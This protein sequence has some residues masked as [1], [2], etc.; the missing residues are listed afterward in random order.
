[1]S[2]LAALRPV[3]SYAPTMGTVLVAA[4]LALGSILVT[5]GPACAC[6]CVGFTPKQAYDH[7]D[8]VFVGRVV[9]RSPKDHFPWETTGVEV[10]TVEVER[11]YKGDVRRRQEIVTMESGASCGLEL[12]GSGPFVVYATRDSYG[13]ELEPGQYAAGL[14]DGSAPLTAGLER[15]LERQAPAGATE[16]AVAPLEESTG[17]RGLLGAPIMAGLGAIGAVVAAIVGWLKLRG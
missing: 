16:P 3:M 4:I 6:S 2:R 12:E 13:I 14:C 17:G 8:A 7:A 5:P 15:A 1:M 11:S 10:W 9:D